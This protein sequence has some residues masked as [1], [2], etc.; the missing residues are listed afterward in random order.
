[1]SG[2]AQS[3]ALTGIDSSYG[4]IGGIRR[5]RRRC[6][7][8]AG[9]ATLE[10]DPVALGNTEQI[11]GAPDDIVLELIDLAI[12]I[13]QLPHHLDDAEPAFLIDR[14]HDDAGEMIEI[15]R[16]AFHQHRGGNQLVRSAGIEPEAGFN[17]PMKLALFDLGWLAIERDDMDQQRRRR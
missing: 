13:S 7:L 15:D 5:A 10:I 3:M 17:P 1:M 8:P 4:G 2:T 14:T 12:G 9:D 6:A 16:L 11:G